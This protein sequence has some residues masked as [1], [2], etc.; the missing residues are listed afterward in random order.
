MFWSPLRRIK[1]G[2]VQTWS[3]WLAIHAADNGILIVSGTAP[4]HLEIGRWT[5]LRLRLAD[6]VRCLGD[7]TARIAHPIARLSDRFVGSRLVDCQPCARRQARLN[8]LGLRL[9]DWLAG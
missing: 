1:L 7:W 4:T 2:T 9:A 6:R 5:F 3:P 8:R